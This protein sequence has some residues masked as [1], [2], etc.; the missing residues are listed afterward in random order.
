MKN[1][2]QPTSGSV[3]PPIWKLT[4]IGGGIL[5]VVMLVLAVRSIIGVLRPSSSRPAVEQTN[6]ETVGVNPKPSAGTPLSSPSGNF[7]AQ[8]S[9]LST[10]DNLQ[11]AVS[12]ASQPATF[13]VEVEIMRQR[14]QARAETIKALK[15]EAQERAGTNALPREELRKIEQSD[16]YIQ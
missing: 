11:T 5:V 15:R 6:S 14:E 12:P 1:N 3:A 4:L 9:P 7:G 16:P 13:A 2:T 10:P 8:I